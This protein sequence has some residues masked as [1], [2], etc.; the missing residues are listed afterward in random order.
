MRIFL[1]GGTGVIGRQLT[2]QLRTAG[3]SVVATTRTEDKMPMLW[4]LGAEP[5]ALDALDGAAVGD[6]VARAEPDVIISQLTA[7]SEVKPD[8]RHFDRTFATTNRLRSEGTDHLIAAGRA[9]GVSRI[10]VQSYTGWPNVRQGGPVKTEADGLD[11]NPPAQQRQAMAAIQ[12][13]EQAV[14]AA[15]M[16]GVVLRYGMLYGHGAS[17][18]LFDQVRAR[19]LPIV[20][21]GGGVWSWTH[22]DDAASA[23]VAALERGRGVYN[24]VDDDPAPTRVV[25][26][27]LAEILGAAPPRRVPVWLARLLAGEVI[28]SMLTEAR[29]SSNAKARRDLDWAPRWSSWRDGVR[30]EFAASV[31][32]R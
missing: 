3:H 25:F 28:V 12:H 21:A 32:A 26:P 1:A 18:E 8:L 11:P 20:G 2:P 14:V 29:G 5:M 9:A 4:N 30:H 13:M 23:A 24:I 10:I 15:P 16:D 27:A 6:A 22:V 31:E 17:M 19:K 7:L